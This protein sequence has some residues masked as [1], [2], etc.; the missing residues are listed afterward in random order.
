MDQ[1]FGRR[2]PATITRPRWP[3]RLGGVALLLSGLAF[4]AGTAQAA[5]TQFALTCVGTET[6]GD[7]N[8]QYRWGPSG[9]WKRADAEP[10]VSVA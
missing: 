3:A 5:D 4:H 2:T 8:F 9:E 7:I 10:G 1:C 6:G